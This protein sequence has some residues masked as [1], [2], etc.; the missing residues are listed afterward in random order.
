MKIKPSTII[1]G[2]QSRQA[3]GDKI[4]AIKYARKRLGC[5]LAEAKEFCDYV[6]WRTGQADAVAD[7]HSD[8]CY[9]CYDTKPCKQPHPEPQI[10]EAVTQPIEKPVFGD[11]LSEPIP[12]EHRA[13][14]TAK[15]KPQ[16]SASVLIEANKHRCPLRAKALHGRVP[17][18]LGGTHKKAR[19]GASGRIHIH[20]DFLTRASVAWLD[21]CFG[22]F[23]CIRARCHE[24]KGITGQFGT[25]LPV[26]ALFSY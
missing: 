21:S 12:P 7:I 14:A 2:I 3:A 1:L 6:A 18:K 5:G 17:R 19:L 13:K 15:S 25:G 10:V 9:E 11:A 26:S 20:L 4:G 23:L 24:C 22:S 8:W 16:P